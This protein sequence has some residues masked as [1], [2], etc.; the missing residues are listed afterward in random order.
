MQSDT[1]FEAARQTLGITVLE[2][3][4]TYFAL[5]GSEDAYALTGYLSGDS[6]P[7]A[8]THDTIAHALNQTFSERGEH[9]PV[10]YHDAQQPHRY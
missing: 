2:L 7:S 3:W 4:F 8:A 6:V 5:G 9:S 10:P 1:P